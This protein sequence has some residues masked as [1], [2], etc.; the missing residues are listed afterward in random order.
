MKFNFG[1]LAVAAVL[2]GA[3]AAA[4]PKQSGGKVKDSVS[5]AEKVD[6]PHGDLTL[7]ALKLPCANGHSCYELQE[8]AGNQRRAHGPPR[9]DGGGSNGD[10]DDDDDDE[11]DHKGHRG[12]RGHHGPVWVSHSRGGDD[13]HVSKGH[14]G[15]VWVSHD[16]DRHGHERRADPD[17]DDEEEESGYAADDESTGSNDVDDNGGQESPDRVFDFPDS[18]GDE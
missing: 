8:K 2:L 15:P 4:V 18:D 6:G 14:K 10:G 5:P 1:F 13:G 16:G 11:N 17:D 3:E 9:G 7:R 12:H